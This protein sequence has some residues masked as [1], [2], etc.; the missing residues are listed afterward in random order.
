MP[1]FEPLDI[2]LPESGIRA[3]ESLHAA[4]FRMGEQVHDFH[5]IFLILRGT[6]TAT[7]TGFGRLKAGPGSILVVPA[8]QRHWFED[9]RA[10][11]LV[12]VA[13]ADAVLD[14]C[15]GRRA[16]WERIQAEFAACPASSCGP[17]LDHRAW[18][19]LLAVEERGDPKLRRLSQETMLNL[20]LQDVRRSVAGPRDLPAETRVRNFANA[21]PE[22]IHEEWSLDR[23]AAQT[24]L[25]RRR[26]SELFREITG[27]SFVNRLQQLRVEAVQE[28]LRA[29][30]HS[31]VGAAYTCGFENVAHFYRVFRRHAGASPGAWLAAYSTE[32]V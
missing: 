24:R 19:E 26:F 8:G 25:S 9:E 11:N 7:V 3:A 12:V 29:G 14:N 22:H 31:I 18:R 1:A 5:E 2:Q 10:S 23:G 32:R 6:T 21:L 28:L 30:S 20:L 27:T 15:P 13:F 4:S 16:L 17:A